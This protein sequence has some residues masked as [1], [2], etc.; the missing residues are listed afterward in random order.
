MSKGYSPNGVRHDYGEGGSVMQ[1]AVSYQGQ[2]YIEVILEGVPLAE[3]KDLDTKIDG[4]Y[5]PDNGRIYMIFSEESET[6][7]LHYRANKI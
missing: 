2:D 7:D 1:R 4:A 5:D 6:V 3:A